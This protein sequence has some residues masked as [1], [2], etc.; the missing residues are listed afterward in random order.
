VQQLVVRRFPLCPVH[1]FSL[2]LG[3]EPTVVAGVVTKG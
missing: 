3:R 2:S 1:G